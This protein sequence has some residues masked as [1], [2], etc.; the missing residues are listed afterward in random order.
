MDSKY[1][2]STKPIL[3]RKP[4]PIVFN[5]KNDN[6]KKIK[7]EDKSNSLLNK[8][9]SNER[10]GK[11][12]LQEQKRRLPIFDKRNQLLNLITRYNTL[13]IIGETGCGKT[14]QIPQYIFS[15][16][17]QGNG[18]IAVTQP[19]RVAAI[20][21]A[22]RVA[23]EM[24]NGSVGDTVGY[25]VRFEDVTSKKTKI[26]FLTDGMLL[27][28][29][30]SDN[31]L[32]NYTVIIL[33]E[34]HERT[35]HTDV[36]FGIVKQA[37]KL[38]NDKQVMPLKVLIMSATMDVDHF[39]QYFNHCKAV[40]IEG[41]TYP[42]N[43]YH[44]IKPQD[45]YQT[46]CVATF[47][48]IHKQAP[49]NHDVLIF[50]TGQ[51][52]IEAVC[53]HIRTL[54]RE[55]DVE[56]PP[57]RVFPLYAAQ[58]SAQQMQVFQSVPINTRKVIVSTN[59]AETSVTI[60]GV[61]YVIDSGMVKV[62]SYNPATG[63]EVLKVNRISQEQAWQRSGRSGRESEGFCYRLYTK[64]QF[65]SMCLS[66]VP[67]IQRVNLANVALQLLALGIHILNFDFMDKPSPES[68]TS[69]FEQ[70]KQLQA[71]EEI[72]SKRL[73]PL[74]SK[75]AQF[76]LDPR[77]S[78]ILISSQEYGCVEE[79][80]TIIAML[81]GE[82]ILFNP[83]S[84]REEAQMMRQRFSSAYGD[85]IM[86]L[87]VFREFNKIGQSNIRSWCQEHY[88]NLRN[89]VYAKQIRLQLQ[90]LCEWCHI[91]ISSCEGKL[92]QIRKCM[93]TG[94]FMNVA[95]LHR[96][97]QYIMLSNK[98]VV[99]IHPS[100]VLHG[101]QPACVI[102]TEVIQ[103]SKCYLRNLLTIEKDWLNEIVPGYAKC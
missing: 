46:A 77:F 10:R 25:S 57:A 48:K 65:D 9:G 71:V 37:Q 102:F 30:I 89:I 42:V 63:F 12:S 11:L 95:E 22:L 82:S 21:I 24:A 70:L 54:L 32:M 34:A 99:N 86:L 39:S 80:L 3:K 45:D 73:T 26:K 2:F 100:S 31:L 58:S 28:E 81:S 79:A 101:Q 41:R 13:V 64:N 90:E 50:L 51:D 7:F 94:L 44:S 60:T 49:P 67:E 78:K 55:P 74:G 97:R 18:K 68:I 92:D 23:Q 75:M 8:H 53:Y 59:V 5:I 91:P 88:I 76:P 93:L 1:N 72:F 38:R 61:K 98:Q 19:R 69:A 85:L 96:D 103:T 4:E 15:A 40:Y 84:K 17:L 56:G 36:L 52:E 6:S 87:N 66:T 16:R 29:A 43:I 14:T 20:S 27:R 62:R 33:D 35:I 47:F 83:P